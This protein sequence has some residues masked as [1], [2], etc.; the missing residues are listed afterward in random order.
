MKGILLPS[1]APSCNGLGDYS[2][3][4]RR[5]GRFIVPDSPGTGPLRALSQPSELGVQV[6]LSGELRAH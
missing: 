6:E 5:K 4:S 1:T 3:S 2:G